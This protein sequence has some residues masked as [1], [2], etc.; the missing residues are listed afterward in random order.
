MTSSGTSPGTGPGISP[1]ELVL[2]INAGSSSL[3]FRLFEAAGAGEPTVLLSGRIEGI[4]VRPRFTAEDESGAA[5][6]RITAEVGLGHHG[7]MRLLIDWLDERLGE[8]GIAIVGH[9]VVHGGAQHAAPVLVDDRVMRELRTMV[10]LAPLHQPHNLDAID[11]VAA[12]YP[13]VPQVACFD[14]AFHRGHPWVAD[15]YALPRHFFDEGLRRYGFHGLSYEYIAKELARIAPA[16]AKGRVV[17]AHLGNGA[18]CCAML[19]GR[20]IDSTMGFTALDGL[21][22]GTRSG[23]IDPGVL[24]HL[25]DAR[26]LDSAAIATLLYHDSGLKGLSGISS[27]M[28]DLEASDRP[29]AAEAIA[30]FAYRARREIGAL[31]AALEGLDGLVFT[32]GIGEHGH[33]VRARIC[34]GLGWLGVELDE[35]ANARNAPV[36]S[37]ASSAVEVRVVP[38]DEER[39]I[40]LH[41]LRVQRHGDVSRSPGD[42]G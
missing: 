33:A 2:V 10:P 5:L 34:R 15:T 29:E 1:G 31:A 9:R 3:K 40:A 27:D 26:G 8:R 7:A 37:T 35:A 18:S 41:A 22:M 28:R 17:A 36:V 11:A 14:T 20:S 16:V 38:T 42:G 24:L 30:Y 23:Q 39:M 6:A 19:A 13:G 21:P 4:G 12:A 32:A 25:I